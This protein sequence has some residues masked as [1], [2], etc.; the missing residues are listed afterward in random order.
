M[1]ALDVKLR[2]GEL[3][4]TGINWANRRILPFKRELRGVWLCCP[5]S[6]QTRSRGNSGGSTQHPVQSCSFLLHPSRAFIGKVLRLKGLKIRVL[7]N[8]LKMKKKFSWCKGCN[9]GLV[10]SGCILGKYSTTEPLPSQSPNIFSFL[11]NTSFPAVSGGLQGKGMSW[12]S[13]RGRSGK[14]V[15]PESPAGAGR[16]ETCRICFSTGFATFLSC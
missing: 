5:K 12:D 2:S 7:K 6:F 15:S 8:N 1:I 3:I 13:G 11:Q 14:T 16:E 10:H 9:P 4:F